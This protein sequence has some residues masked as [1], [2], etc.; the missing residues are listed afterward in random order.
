MRYSAEKYTYTV[1]LPAEEADVGVFGDQ[2]T[3]V[4]WRVLDNGKFYLGQLTEYAAKNL[5]KRLNGETP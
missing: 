2:E 4:A 3:R 1:T 5:V